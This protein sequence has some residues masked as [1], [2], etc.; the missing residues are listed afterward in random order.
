MDFFCQQLE[1]VQQDPEYFK[2]LNEELEHDTGVNVLGER[3][4]K[5]GEKK[6]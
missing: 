5:R 4:E 3:A 6:A 1:Y 2:L